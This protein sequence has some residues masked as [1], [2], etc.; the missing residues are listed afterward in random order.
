M[1]S[2]E[3]EDFLQSIIAIPLRERSWKKLVKLD[4]FHAFYGGP[5]PT[6]EAKRLDA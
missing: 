2:E 4:S 6:N 5:A 3:E 1:I